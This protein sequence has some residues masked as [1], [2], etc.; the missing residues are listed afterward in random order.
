[1]AV[2]SASR[3]LPERAPPK[4]NCNMAHLKTNADTDT[5]AL[6]K[7]EPHNNQRLNAQI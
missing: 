4:I 6:V 5:A 7:F 1:M 2:C 3:L